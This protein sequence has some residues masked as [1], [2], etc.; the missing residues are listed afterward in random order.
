MADCYGS[1]DVI[2]QFSYYLFA[3]QDS[4]LD[5]PMPN[6]C[7]E[8]GNMESYD[9]LRECI[10][11]LESKSSGIGLAATS[12]RDIDL[13]RD[14]LD[15]VNSSSIDFMK[16]ESLLRN[17]EESARSKDEKTERDKSTNINISHSIRHFDTIG[18][19]CPNFSNCMD[20]ESNDPATSVNNNESYTFDKDQHLERKKIGNYNCSVKSYTGN[21]IDTDSS[22]NKDSY[23]NQN[24]TSELKCEIKIDNLELS[25]SDEQI[26]RCKQCLMTFR[27]K[28]HLDRHLEGHQKNNCPHCNEKFARRKHLEVHLFR[29]HGERVVRHPHLCDVC[30]KSFPKRALL[31]RHRAKH[32]YQSGRVCSECGD[33]INADVDEKEHE[34]QCKKR[35][36]KCQQCLQTF[37]IEQTYLS[38]IQNHDNYKC[39]CCDITFASKK[40][41]HE[42][43]KAAHIP[44]L[45]KQESTNGDEY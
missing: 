2:Q 43:F 12:A 42:H 7:T 40:K 22:I 1:S 21:N 5:D 45:S 33:M 30:P 3:F 37:S 16:I 10:S 41:A 36:F 15:D 24:I 14:G 31:N 27:Y 4:T 28:R 38:H 25:D 9:Y 13:Q 29:A 23:I 34:N 32:S 35:Q 17:A 26:Q 8:T 6:M 19:N 11:S 44:K 18:L 20:K 39:P